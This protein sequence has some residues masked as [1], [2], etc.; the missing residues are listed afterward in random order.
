VVWVRQRPL[1]APLAG[2]SVL[3]AGNFFVMADVRNR[4]LPAGEAITFD[5]AMHS[6][7]NRLGNV[8]SFPYNLYVAWRY[9]TDAL[10]YDRL[11][12]RSYN[13]I[14]IDFGEDGDET[15]LGH[16]WSDREHNAST[17]Y[18]W[19]SGSVSS[20]IVP[21]R[22]GDRYR[23]E[24]A[25][26]PFTYPNGPEQVLTLEVNRRVAATIALKP[27][28]QTYTVELAA[29]IF[30]PNLNLI[31]FRYAYTKSPAEAGLSSD[32]RSLGV[33]FDNLKL[34]RQLDDAP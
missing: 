12:G 22:S 8:F 6:V 26:E 7:S 32:A 19:S 15:L 28:L 29:G 14:E 11:K 17:N 18:R 2:I 27:G 23:V 30:H 1:G 9:D 21:L 24:I 31:Q 10:F 34:K 25:C 16:G 13:N 5:D 33:L 4:Q 3:I 20:V